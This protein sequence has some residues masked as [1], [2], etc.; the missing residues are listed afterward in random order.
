MDQVCFA[1][2][3]VAVKDAESLVGVHGEDADEFLQLWAE[4]CAKREPYPVAN[5]IMVGASGGSWEHT[6]RG[7][8]FQAT[9]D[10]LRPEGRLVVDALTA[11]YGEAPLLL[12][13]LDT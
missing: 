13:W 4:A 10:D 3:F 6:R 2:M 11:V 1:G 9:L 5:V 8:W 12:T 7:T